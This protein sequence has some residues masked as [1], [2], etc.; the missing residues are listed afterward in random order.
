MAMPMTS[1]ER[2]IRALSH[3]PVWPIPRD[4]WA[5]PSVTELRKDEYQRLI[6][7]FPNDFAKPDCQYGIGRK[8]KGEKY[9][10]GK[11]TDA[12]GCVWHA[13]QYGVIGEV[14]HPPLSDWSKLA[15]YK[16][17]YE[18]LDEADFSNVNRSCA[19]TDCFVLPGTETR[20]FERLQFLRGSEAVYIDLAYG[21]G[22]IRKV[23][24][25]LHDFYCREL[26]MWA[27][28]DVDGVS[29]MDDWGA[30]NS[31]L[32]SPEMWRDIFKPLYRDYVEIM[33]A[34]GKYIFFHSDGYITDIYPDLVE[35]GIDAIN[36]QLFCMD[37]EELGRRFGGKITFWGEIDRQYVLPF[38]TPDEVRAAVRRVRKALDHGRGGMIAQAEWGMNDPYEN[39]EAVFDEWN[40]PMESNSVD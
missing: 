22:E 19:E 10:V 1:R 32:I 16:P 26:R 34:K 20:P 24:E 21:A 8:S 2:V 31:M 29:F 36:S 17:P 39:I 6:D 25:M 28:T 4:I 14:K 3:E 7:K 13:A 35:L 27:D 5:L 12:W 15:D 33:H 37:I 23:L 38:G 11:Y 30:Q 18:L 40:K 9:Q